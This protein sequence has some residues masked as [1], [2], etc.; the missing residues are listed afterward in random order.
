VADMFLRNYWYVAAFGHEV[1]RNLLARTILGDK[2]VLYRTEG[3]S[4]IAL[5][6]RCCHRQAPLSM[7]HLIGDTVECGYHGLVFDTSGECVRVPGQKKYR[8]VPRFANTQWQNVGGGFGSGWGI[9]TL[10]MKP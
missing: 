1:G 8:Q 10:Q 2:I 7:G 4:P 9:P 6:N 5:A 3:G